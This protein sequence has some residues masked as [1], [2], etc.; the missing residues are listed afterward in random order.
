MRIVLRR[1]S[2]ASVPLMAASIAPC[3][4]AGNSEFRVCLYRKSKRTSGNGR[5]P[6][7]RSAARITARRALQS[8]NTCSIFLSNW[9][10]SLSNS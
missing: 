9:R 4:R 5:I 2:S 6:A 8:E 7:R 10:L 3:E 1:A